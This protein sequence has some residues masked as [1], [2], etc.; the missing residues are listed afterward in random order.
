M[1]TLL[2]ALLLSVILLAGCTNYS[3]PASTSS[4]VSPTPSSPAPSS[5]V[6]PP[7]SAKAS[8]SISNFAFS[9]ATLTVAKGTAVTWTN[10]DGA[11]HTVTSTSGAFDSGSLANG[12]SFTF[13]FSTPGTYT[14]RCNIHTSMT[15][16]IVVTG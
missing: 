9:P 7:S 4:V 15:G 3:T 6:S 14:Y 1:K 10:N 12:K 11:P 16:Q 13:T 8:V 2:L 5:V